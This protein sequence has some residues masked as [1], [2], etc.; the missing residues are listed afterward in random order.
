MAG[1]KA[2]AK[3]IDVLKEPGSQFHRD[4]LSDPPP[5]L[6]NPIPGRH[7]E[8]ERTEQISDKEGAEPMEARLGGQ[9][10]RCEHAIDEILWCDGFAAPPQSRRCH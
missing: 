7:P 10:W 9:S 8:N 1:V 2:Q 4:L 5:Q 6:V 3:L